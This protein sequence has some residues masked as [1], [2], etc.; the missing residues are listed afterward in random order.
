MFWDT[1][2]NAIPTAADQDL[3]LRWMA[4]PEQTVEAM[5]LLATLPARV[6]YVYAALALPGKIRGIWRVGQP[7][8]HL[9]GA[10][11]DRDA[12]SAAAVAALADRPGTPSYA[13]IYRDG[14]A[15]VFE[16]YR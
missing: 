1:P 6:E 4:S 8:E 9:P 15:A 10:Y 12:A 3:A 16:D 7:V 2:A 11:L 5:A 13:V 14:Y